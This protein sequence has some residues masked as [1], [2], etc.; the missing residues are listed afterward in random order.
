M[1]ET[2]LL[3]M[4]MLAHMR[5]TSLHCTAAVALHNQRTTELQPATCNLQLQLQ[6]QLQISTQEVDAGAAELVGSLDAA[7]PSLA[8]ALANP[9]AQTAVR[10][11]IRELLLH[12][13]KGHKAG[14]T[15]VQLNALQVRRALQL[16]AAGRL[17]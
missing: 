10:T 17:V 8:G 3:T 1:I 15:Q 13:A 14:G 12:F 2:T 7:Q 11:G 9:E 5:L 6:L 4:L 16:P